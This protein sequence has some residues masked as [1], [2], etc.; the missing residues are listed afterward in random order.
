MIYCLR[1]YA[2]VTKEQDCEI[3]HSSSQRVQLRFPCLSP[4]SKAA[5]NGDTQS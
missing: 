1:A 3:A 2:R 4:V 5:E